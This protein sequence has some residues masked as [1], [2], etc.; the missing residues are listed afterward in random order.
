ME[1][2]LGSHRPHPG[3]ERRPCSPHQQGLGSVR[4]EAGAA[5][6]P[7]CGA[8][9][10]SDSLSLPGQH[11]E[12]PSPEARPPVPC[13]AAIPPGWALLPGS[14]HCCS[15]VTDAATACLTVTS[16]PCSPPPL[17]CGAVQTGK[18]PLFSL[19]LPQG[20]VVYGNTSGGW[21]GWSALRLD[22]FPSGA[23][24]PLPPP[25]PGKAPSRSTSRQCPWE[26]HLCSL[27][28]PPPAIPWVHV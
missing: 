2:R 7:S 28:V 27:V 6:M 5:A 24:S 17:W 11:G 3:R 18:H 13:A 15:V 4:R 21:G 19:P 25:P 9:A 16:S 1:P 10:G 20:G 23:F 22:P 26:H 14:P 12:D 8:G